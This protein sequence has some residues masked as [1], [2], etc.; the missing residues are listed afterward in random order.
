MVFVGND[1]VDLTSPRTQGR[2]SDVR[3]VTR[4]FDAKE[5]EAI[6]AARGSDVELWSRWAAK[7]AGYKAISKTTADRP[8]FLHRAFKVDWSFAKDLAEEASAP[9]EDTV[10]RVGIVTHADRVADVSV[11]LRA[12]A[13]HAVAVCTSPPDVSEIVEIHARVERL[14][15]PGSCWSGSLEQ[16]MR[17]FSEREA[18]AVRSLESAAVRL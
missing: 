17:R 2:V 7:E 9:A 13:V 3:F 6:R 5:Q 16:L 11:R 1:V 15:D 12:G 14:T 10:V 4:V 18:D 8:S